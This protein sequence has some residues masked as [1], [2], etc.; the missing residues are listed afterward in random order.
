MVYSLCRP[1]ERRST[2]TAG[3]GAGASTS[4]FLFVPPTAGTW[5]PTA[6][7]PTPYSKV[8][9]A[10]GRNRQPWAGREEGFPTLEPYPVSYH[11]GDGASQR[12]AV[13][14]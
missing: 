7:G 4:A 6:G 8:P 11:T 14:S 12:C 3:Q 13:T 2:C 9:T 10:T 1:L 5:P